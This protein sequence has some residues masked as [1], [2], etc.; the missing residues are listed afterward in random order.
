MEKSTGY[1][2]PKK[3]GYKEQHGVIVIC[4]NERDQAKVYRQLRRTVK[5]REVKVVCT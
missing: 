1:P 2:R 3:P 5:P 4:N